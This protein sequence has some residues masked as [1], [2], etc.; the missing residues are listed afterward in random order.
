MAGATEREPQQ[1]SPAP[2]TPVN[3]DATAYRCLGAEAYR[4]A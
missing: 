1:F 4:F 3:V 2:F